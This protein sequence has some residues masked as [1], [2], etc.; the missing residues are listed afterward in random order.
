M[1]WKDTA[2]KKLKANKDSTLTIKQKL[3]FRYLNLKIS[4]KM[5]IGF[6]TMALLCSVLIGTVGVVNILQI[7]NMSNTIYQENIAPLTPLYEISTN[8]LHLETELRDVGIGKNYT[9]FGDI[10]KL[11]EDTLYKIQFYS[12]SVSSD[13]EA[14]YLRRLEEDIDNLN[15]YESG[16]ESELA[17]KNYDGAYDM[18]YGE[19][20]KSAS[21]FDTTI[22]K[23]FELKTSQ[24]KSRNLSNTQSFYIALLVMSGIMLLAIAF[25]V[26]IGIFNAK[27]ICKPIEK[28]VNAAD[29]ISSGNLDVMIDDAAKDETGILSRAFVKIGRSLQLLKSDVDMLISC[30]LEGRLD[31]RADILR[32]QG[33]YRDIID[34]VNH[35]LDAITVPLNTATDY[36]GRIGSGE[37]PEL[38]SDEYK[39]DFNKLKI[40]LNNCINAINGLVTD[41]KTLSGAATE[42]DLSARVDVE[43]HQGDY[44]RIIECVNTTLDVIQKSAK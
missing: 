27:I 17:T 2:S 34:G 24:A 13:E 25:S 37:I 26:F 5:V 14:S 1:Q 44:R 30:T 35:S 6:V 7:N 12:N 11:Q 20:S 15:I 9:T 32:H 33:A 10:S 31:V 16:I 36:F 23:L 28:L 29:A 22:N 43:K 19:M 41:A 39:G 21:D 18:L 42:G 38:I 4:S 3:M 40:N 8:F